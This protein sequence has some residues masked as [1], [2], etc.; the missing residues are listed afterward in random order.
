MSKERGQ[1][2]EELVAQYLQKNNFTVI[3]RNYQCKMGEIDLI[4]KQKNLIVF[5]EVKMRTIHYFDATELVPFH[6][7]A[8]II[9]T[10]RHYISSTSNPDTS[11]R[12]DVALVDGSTVPHTI[13]YIPDAFNTQST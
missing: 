12:F 13:T 6:K 9:K 8:K 11:F 5:V 10:A 2:A 7:Q 1:I 3:E 4:G